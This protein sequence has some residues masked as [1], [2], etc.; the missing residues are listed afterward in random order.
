MLSSLYNY[1]K[2][3][4]I[5]EEMLKNID[6]SVENGSNKKRVAENCVATE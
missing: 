6:K 2:D 5:L 3:N 1:I 4:K